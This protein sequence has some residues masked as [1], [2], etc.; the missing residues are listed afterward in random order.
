M[1]NRL[2]RLVCV[3]LQSLIRNSVVDGERS[4]RCPFV[5][6][7]CSQLKS[8]YV[9]RSTRS[10][11]RI[12]S[13]LRCFFQVRILRFC[14]ATS[15]GSQ[16][17]AYCMDLPAHLPDAQNSGGGGSVPSTGHQPKRGSIRISC[18]AVVTRPL[19]TQTFS[20]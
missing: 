15:H 8:A 17:H 6:R 20:T 19:R 3:F 5:V 7:G 1:Q 16:L 2:V 14:L 13:F 9:T 4:S 10:I 12:A 18:R 11:Y